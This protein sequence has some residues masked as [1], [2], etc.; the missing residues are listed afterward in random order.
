M[1]TQKGERNIGTALVGGQRHAPGA[2]PPVFRCGWASRFVWKS[3]GYL[4]P[5]GV[6]NLDH[7]KVTILQ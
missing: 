5:T 2:L 4:A 6:Q 7:L 1:K 3:K